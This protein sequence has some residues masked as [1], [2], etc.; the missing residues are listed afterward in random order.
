MII[1]WRKV[2]N[3]EVEQLIKLLYLSYIWCF[4]RFF[5]SLT[6]LNTS[7]ITLVCLESS[8]LSNWFSAFSAGILFCRFVQVVKFLFLSFIFVSDES[9]L[10]AI[11]WGICWSVQNRTFVSMG[12]GGLCRGKSFLFRGY[13]P[14]VVYVWCVTEVFCLSKAKKI[15]MAMCCFK[16]ANSL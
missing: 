1:K 10:T 6:K 2:R 9:V 14:K 16:W 15:T 5:V 12:F 8:F 11:E 3:F 7:S 4:V 13:L